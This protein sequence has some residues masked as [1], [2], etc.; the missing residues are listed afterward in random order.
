MKFPREPLVH[1]LLLGVLLF[2]LNRFFNGSSQSSS[3]QITVPSGLLENL[4]L[5]FKRSAGRPPTPQ[6]LNQLAEDYVREEVLNREARVLGLDRDD[7]V[8]RQRLRQRMEF[9]LEDDAATAAPTDAEL[10][11]YLSAHPSSFLPKEGGKLPSLA[12]IRNRVLQAWMAE[13]RKAGVEE[14]YQKL[15]QHYTVNIEHLK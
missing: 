10:Q 5:G 11:E 12:E 2:G 4:S 9:A 14:A 15:R 1:F 13:R 8:V 3:Y 6:E 7:P